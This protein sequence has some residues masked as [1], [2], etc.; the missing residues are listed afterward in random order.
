MNAFLVETQICKAFPCSNTHLRLNEVN[1]CNFFSNSVL[2][3]DA[4]VHFNEYVLSCT[5]TSC[6]YQELNSSSVLV[7]D[8][9]SESYCVTMESCTEFFRN[10]RSRCNFDNLLVAALYRAV[11]FKKMNSFTLAVSEYLNLD[12]ARTKYCLLQEHATI[13]ESTFGF[14]HSGFKCRTKLIHGLNAAHT[15]ATTTSNSLGED[16][17]TDVMGLSDQA[18]NVCGCF[19]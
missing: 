18:V 5:F 14:T 15:A 11:T 10:I 1:I 16:G 2:D 4:R 3:L 6:V 12:V 7:A 17:E 9:A 8:G 13:A 19:S